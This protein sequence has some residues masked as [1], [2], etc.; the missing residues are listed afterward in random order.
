MLSLGTHVVSLVALGLWAGAV[1]ADAVVAESPQAWI[2][3]QG[4]KAPLFDFFESV[5][6]TRR[7]G[8]EVLLRRSRFVERETGEDAFREVIVSDP[9]GLQLLS[10]EVEQLQLDEKGSIIV[11]RAQKKIFFRYYKNKSWRETSEVLQ[12]PFLVGA[13]VPRY[14]QKHGKEMLKSGRQRFHL[15]VPYMVKSFTFNLEPEG[16]R[17]FEGRSMSSFKMSPSHFLVSAVVKPLHFLYDVE[18][19]RVRQ[20]LGRVFL[21]KRTPSGWESFDA[22]T[23]FLDP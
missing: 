20:I 22:E 6:N 9:S 12:E 21:K 3:E 1:S 19:V 5:E 10:Y 15:A 17:E 16:S 7:D 23:L 13:M 4:A 11:D 8:A 2:R 18:S 14:I